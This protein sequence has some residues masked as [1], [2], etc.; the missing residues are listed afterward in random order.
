MPRLFVAAVLLLLLA[1][2]VWLLV[3]GDAR[4]AD[5]GT[6]VVA[7]GTVVR[8]AVATGVVEPAQ[9]AQVNTALAGFVRRHHVTPGQKVAAGDPLCE[10]WPALTERDLLAAERQLLAAAEGEATAREF[11]QGEHLL[12]HLTRMLQ[13]DRNLQRMQ[14]SAERGRRSAEESLR[15]LREGKVEI[16]GRTIDFVVRAPVAGHVLQL[17]RIGDPV[18]PASNFGLGT[19]VAVLGDLDAPVFRGTVDEIDVGRLQVGMAGRITLGALPGVALAGKVVEIGLRARRQDNAALFDVRIAVEP[20][21]GAQ[22]RAGYSAVAE[23]ELARVENVPTIPERVVWH[24]GEQAF[25]R[26]PGADGQPQERSVTLGLGDGLTVE[27]RDGLRVG[28][29]VFE[30]TASRP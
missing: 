23:V 13:G 28:D 9:E 18:T 20:A 17:A 29:V 10:V 7:T 12:S 5:T 19:V 26:V 21:S 27:V 8:K 30:R 24:R 16:D 25:V 1:V 3:R 11:A 2:P 4:A 6:L 22:L 14:L 15:L